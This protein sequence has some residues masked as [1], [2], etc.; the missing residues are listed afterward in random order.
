MQP[1]FSFELVVPYL[2]L[3]KSIVAKEGEGLNISY[4]YNIFIYLVFFLLKIVPF[5]AIRSL[6]EHKRIKYDF[7]KAV[8]RPWP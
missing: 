1:I 3:D 6:L 4:L 2:T 7:R 8:F 5:A